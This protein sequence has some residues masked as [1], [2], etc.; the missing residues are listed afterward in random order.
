MTLSPII[1]ST[2]EGGSTLP[3]A[4]SPDYLPVCASKS[5]Q[6][7][8]LVYCNDRT[9]ESFTQLG[10]SAKWVSRYAQDTWEHSL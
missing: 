8:F 9:V 5:P 10:L 3:L 2:N 4:A 7:L 1:Q 6:V